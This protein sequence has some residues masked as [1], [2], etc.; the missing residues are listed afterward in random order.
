MGYD[1]LVGAVP[2]ATRADDLP[3]SGRYRPYLA[4]RDGKEQIQHYLQRAAGAPNAR[5]ILDAIL[6]TACARQPIYERRPRETAN[7]ILAVLTHSACD[8]LLLDDFPQIAE[9][10]RPAVLEAASYYDYRQQLDIVAALAEHLGTEP[11]SS[12]EELCA[13]AQR[14]L[15]API[16]A[17]PAP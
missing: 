16:A 4:S 3:C 13:V 2:S 11:T 14:A 8:R 1:V 7:L 17:G 15:E 9:R 10:L 5:V 6:Q 12:G